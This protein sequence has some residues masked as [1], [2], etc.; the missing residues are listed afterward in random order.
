MGHKYFV[1]SKNKVFAFSSDM[2]PALV[3]ENGDEVVFET[4]DCFSNQIRTAEDRL[5]HLNWSEV[6]PATGPVF[7]EGAKPG[8]ALVVKILDVEVA[9][10]GVMIAGKGLGPLGEKFESF[11]TKIV[12]IENGCAIFNNLELPID[13]MIGVIGVAPKEGSVNCGTPGPHGGNLD[14][15]CIK[16]G[17]KVI[18]PV[19]VEGGLLALG[20]LHALMGDGEVCGTGIEVAGKVTARIFVK[21]G[22]ELRNPMVISE[23][24]LLTLASARTLDEAMKS[25][26]SDMAEF[27]LRYANISL[28]ELTMLFSIVGHAEISQ[29]VDPLVTVRFR[30]PLDV[31]EK[32]G[33]PKDTIGY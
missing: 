23:G 2:K 31:L 3:I 22:L 20:D 15:R 11:Y 7:L 6:N 16:K 14:T 24:S 9:N 29:V 28:E 30:M 18:L 21:K 5:E 19:F 8:D 10:Q 26:V 33:F 27:V 13:P 1:S 4:M 12:K 25:A 32:L 17:T